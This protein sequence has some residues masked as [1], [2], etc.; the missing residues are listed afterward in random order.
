MKLKICQVQ[1][2]E[3]EHRKMYKSEKMRLKRNFE[4]LGRKKEFQRLIQ[5]VSR[6]SRGRWEKGIRENKAM[7][8][9]QVIKVNKRKTKY[10]AR[11]R[12]NVQASE[13]NEAEAMANNADA[14][15]KNIIEDIVEWAKRMS[16]PNPERTKICV[17]V[18]I[19]GNVTVDSEER[20][21]LCLNP[22]FIEYGKIRMEDIEVDKEVCNTKVR[23][24]EKEKIYQRNE[25]QSVRIVTKD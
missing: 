7:I 9:R 16:K 1:K 21:A 19:F 25:R 6:Q 10:D 4:K 15:A 2:T 17:D 20:D 12:L 14:D 11:N 8:D 22:K 23:W 24:R 13:A 5:R 18:P 3:K